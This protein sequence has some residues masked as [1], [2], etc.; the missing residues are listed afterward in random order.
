MKKLLFIL[1]ALPFFVQ[2]QVSVYTSPTPTQT[3]SNLRVGLSEKNGNVISQKSFPLTSFL[4]SPTIKTSGKI[5]DIIAKQA[6]DSAYYFGNSITVGTNGNLQ[7]LY[8]WSTRVSNAL[9]TNE[10]NKG[11]LATTMIHLSTGDS[12]MQD[13]LALIPTY[14]ST[15]RYLFFEYGT[16]DAINNL[17]TAVFRSSYNTV[18]TNATSKGWSAS[19]IVLL[20]NTYRGIT[21]AGRDTSFR[22]IIRSVAAIVGATFVDTYTDIINNGRN[23]NLFSDSV[24]PNY[25]GNIVWANSVLNTL[26]DNHGGSVQVNGY[27]TANSITVFPFPNQPSNT[28]LF[29]ILDTAQYTASNL[30]LLQLRVPYN[31]ATNLGFG[32]ASL[33]SLTTGANNHGFGY[34]ALK[35]VSS[36]SQNTAFGYTTG[37]LLTTGTANTFIGHQSGHSDT[38][39][40]YNTA[41]GQNALYTNKSG[42]YNSAIGSGSLQALTTGVNNTAVGVSTLT[43]ITTTGNNTAIGN[44]ALRLNT[45]ANNTAVGVSAGENNVNGQY[46]VYLGFLAGQNETA[47]YKFYASIGAAYNLLYGD[48]ISHYLVVNASSTPSSNGTTLQVNGGFSTI[49]VSKT[50]AYTLTGADYT[51]L[52]DATSGA[53]SFTLP[54]ATSTA[55]R[56]YI[57]KKT[58]ASA[59][60]ITVATSSSQTIDGATT[61]SLSTQYKRVQLQSDGTTWQIINAN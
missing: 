4:S 33:G 39:G 8:K 57:I 17:D 52:G 7:S 19:K 5:G 22:N 3:Y 45:N 18:I 32:K 61:Y 6:I 38:S 14:R 53:F 34:E 26:P 31:N 13:R 42:N 60:A 9:N 40:G 23:A 11:I 36:G 49:T 2:G 59:N 16:N 46:G 47:N 56:I 30:G 48:F 1:F 54:S 58:D 12:C 25:Y 10:V 24:H 20:A 28:P 27:V 21:N 29:Q 43:S 50:A 15:L 51:V 55:G 35:S 37:S 44:N 41:I